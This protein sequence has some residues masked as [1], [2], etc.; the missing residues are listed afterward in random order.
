[1]LIKNLGNQGEH[2]DQEPR[3]DDGSNLENKGQKSLP[4]L[5]SLSNNHENA[6]IGP[7]NKDIFQHNFIG[8]IQ[9]NYQAKAG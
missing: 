5:R 8:D 7:I 1:M 3:K 9:L 4:I 2:V 6:K